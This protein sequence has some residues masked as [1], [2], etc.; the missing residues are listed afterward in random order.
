MRTAE[1]EVVCAGFPQSPLNPEAESFTMITPT[2]E[3]PPTGMEQSPPIAI[4]LDLLQEEVE[5]ACAQAPSECDRAWC[6][7]HPYARLPMCRHKL[8]FLLWQWTC[9]WLQ[10]G[11]L[12]L[13]IM[14][15]HPPS[16]NSPRVYH[17]NN[18]VNSGKIWFTLVLFQYKI[19]T[20][21]YQSFPRCLSRYTPVNSGSLR[22]TPVNYGTPWAT[23]GIFCTLGMRSREILWEEPKFNRNKV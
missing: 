15:E 19:C 5:Y 17:D 1:P 8:Y 22:Y 21:V 20:G 18:L 7:W 3:A 13:C 12:Q 6:P 11:I 14:V 23:P 9:L 4:A 10:Y 16:W 2:P